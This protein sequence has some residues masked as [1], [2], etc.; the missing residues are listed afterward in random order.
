MRVLIGWNYC[1]YQKKVSLTE[2]P[3]SSRLSTTISHT[4]SARSLT[5][6]TASLKGSMFSSDVSKSAELHESNNKTDK[7]KYSSL[8]NLMIWKQLRVLKTGLNSSRKIRL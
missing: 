8:N 6:P 3:A 1:H 2:P 7:T 5:L 4:S